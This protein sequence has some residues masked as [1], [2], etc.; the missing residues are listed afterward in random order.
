M[1]L[2]SPPEPPPLPSPDEAAEGALARPLGQP[3]LHRFLEPGDRVAVIAP[4]WEEVE[5]LEFAVEAIFSA[6]NRAGVA[7]IGLYTAPDE[8]APRDWLGR[9]SFGSMGALRPI[10]RADKLVLASRISFHPLTGFGGGGWALAEVAA[11]PATRAGLFSSGALLEYLARLPPIFLLEAAFQRGGRPAALFA[12]E[13]QAG[14]A[15][16]RAYW[17]RWRAADVGEGYQAAIADLPSGGRAAEAI[18]LAS[19][20]LRTGGTLVLIGPPPQ[21]PCPLLS[22]AL[23]E[24]GA[25]HELLFAEDLESARR[26]ARIRAPSGGLAYL[27]DPLRTLPVRDLPRHPTNQVPSAA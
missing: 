14:H 10:A 4:R 20:A 22:R 7:A 15:L 5:D 13:L 23:D 9:A 2:I 24:L 19:R 16:A 3:A 25:E 8:A 21:P 6:A 12:G 11:D 27:P 17:R 26:L 1:D 18:L